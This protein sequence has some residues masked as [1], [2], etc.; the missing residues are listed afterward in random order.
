[1]R[2]TLDDVLKMNADEL[3]EH[4]GLAPGCDHGLRAGLGAIIRHVRTAERRLA[5]LDVIRECGT[6]AVRGFAEELL[7]ATDGK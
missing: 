4:L 7:A 6:V 1:M 3:R 5:I 2:T